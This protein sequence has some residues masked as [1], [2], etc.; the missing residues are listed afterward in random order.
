MDNDVVERS[1]LVELKDP[2]EPANSENEA[3]DVHPGGLIE[4]DPEVPNNEAPLRGEEEA[5]EMLDLEDELEQERD[6]EDENEEEE[7][8]DEE[9]EEEN[10][11]YDVNLVIPPGNINFYHD[12]KWY[13]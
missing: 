5:F 12:F 3:E 2:E 4:L 7:E 6:D 10:P 1:G 13:Y 11:N 9:E 8:E